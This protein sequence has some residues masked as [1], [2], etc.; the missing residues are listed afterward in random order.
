MK[1]Y[2]QNVDVDILINNKPVKQYSKDGE[3]FIEAKDG[4]EY[5]IRL[6]NNN[7]TRIEAVIGVD[8]ID[9][10][11]G[12]PNTEKSSGYV[13]DAY[14]TLKL[15]GFRIS[16]EKV[17]AFKFCKKEGS[18]A[19]SKTVF[20]QNGVITV[21]C[22]GEEILLTFYKSSPQV[23][24]VEDPIILHKRKK[25]IYEYEE[26]YTTWTWP[27]NPIRFGDINSPHNNI[28]CSYTSNTNSGSNGITQDSWFTNFVGV[29]Q[30]LSEAKK[31][32][33]PEVPS[34][35]FDM[36]SSFGSP[37]DSSVK[38]VSF[39]RGYNLGEINIYYASRQGLR[40]AGVNITNEQKVVL[41][42]GTSKYCQPPKD[43]KG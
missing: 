28:T 43:W 11:T 1:N 22:Y 4:T 20:A 2:I 30:V 7:S 27:N 38:G 41:P 33:E 42:Q 29:N 15:K 36:G 14:D 39:I 23:I 17:A 35:C 34:D 24:E 25:Y 37:K 10:I 19:S 6:K 12:N 32:S 5:E 26:P 21:K 18:Y 16:D 9:V 13:I 8:G 40:D 31:C 3:I